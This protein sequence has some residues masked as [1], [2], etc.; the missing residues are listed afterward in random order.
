M[1]LSRSPAPARRAKLWLVC[2]IPALL[3]LIYAAFPSKQSSTAVNVNSSGLQ[4]LSVDQ[5][6]VPPADSPVKRVALCFFGLT[7]SL[8]YTLPS[9]QD[10][11]IGQLHEQGFEVDVFLHTYSDVTHLKN[12]RTG[13][14]DD[15]DADQW[16]MLEPYDY[17]LTSQDDFVKQVKCVPISCGP[18]SRT[19]LVDSVARTLQERELQACPLLVWPSADTCYT[20]KCMRLS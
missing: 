6:V 15:L 14:D 7:R 10:N 8:N 12:G 13:E 9:I 19:V 17:S 4:L 1:D 5:S 3:L 18:L 2:M 11:V 16:H 20:R